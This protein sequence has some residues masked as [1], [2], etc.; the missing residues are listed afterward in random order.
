MTNAQFRRK[1]ANELASKVAGKWFFDG[2]LVEGEGA[3]IAVEDP[4]KN[5]V[6]CHVP[7]CTESEVNQAVRLAVQTQRELAKIPSKQRAEALLNAAADIRANAEHLSWL[8]ALET[9]K[10]L[11]TET[12]G[13]LNLIA[14]IFEYFGGLSMEMK[15]QTVPFS[16]SVLAYTTREPIGVVAG[17]VPWNMPLMFLGYKL[18]G[19][20]LTGNACVVKAPETAPLT[21]LY[22]GSLIA[23]HFPNGAINIL[24]G[25]G[26]TTGQALVSHPDIAKI[27]FTGSVETGRSVYQSAAANLKKVNLELGGKSPMIVLPDADFDTVVSGAVNGIRF[28]RQAQSCTSTTRVFVP[29]SIYERFVEK[30]QDA[31]RKLIIGDP[32]DDATDTGAVI[33]QVQ[34]KRIQGFLDRARAEGLETIACGQTPSEEDFA[35]G[36]FIEP[37][38]ILDPPAQSE[39]VQNEV[40]G[41]VMCIFPYRDI[42]DLPS[43]ANDTKFGLSAS[44]WGRDISQCIEMS[45]K[46][47]VGFVQINQNAVMLPG[48]SYA[49]T[50]ASGFGCESSLETVLTSFTSEKTTIVNIA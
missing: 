45:S 40:F 33:T 23:K 48:L 16:P 46:L 7:D 27:S 37:H 34:L 8:L 15:G 9:G 12:A 31:S 11:R 30:V 44:I 6:I 26:H 10:A 22:V 39:I 43:L 2:S 28:T 25:Y 18:A 38:F 35:K 41:P 50:K 1:T 20:L 47:D 42:G 5:K 29:E 21:V 14:D 24:V 4:S 49:G 3:C 19:P 36:A 13:E 17:I 32:L